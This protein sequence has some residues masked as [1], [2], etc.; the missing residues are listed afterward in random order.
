[1]NRELSPAEEQGWRY[2][3]SGWIICPP[4]VERFLEEATRFSGRQVLW[5]V[6]PDYDTPIGE[7]SARYDQLCCKC[8]AKPPLLLTWKTQVVA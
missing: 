2:F 6:P 8:G 3:W 4:C 1:V 5:P 7:A